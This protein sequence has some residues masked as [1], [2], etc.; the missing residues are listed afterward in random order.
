MALDISTLLISRAESFF[1]KMNAAYIA[2][3]KL[4]QFDVGLS[5]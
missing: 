5:I 2:S 1:H 4:H 3:M